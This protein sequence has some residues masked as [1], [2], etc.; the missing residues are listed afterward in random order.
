LYQDA[1]EAIVNNEALQKAVSVG[2]DLLASAD[3]EMQAAAV[4]MQGLFRGKAT[5][6]SMAAGEFKP[7]EPKSGGPKVGFSRN[8]MMAAFPKENPV[9]AFLKKALGVAG[10]LPEEQEKPN[11]AYDIIEIRKRQELRAQEAAYRAS[12]AVSKADA[13]FNAIDVNGDGVLTREEFVEK[14]NELEGTG[15]AASL[16]AEAVPAPAAEP[17][18]ALPAPLIAQEFRP[19]TF[20]RGAIGDGVEEAVT[21]T[22]D[23]ATEEPPAPPASMAKQ[24]S[25]QDFRPTTFTRGAIGEAVE[26]VATGTP[27]QTPE[28]TAAAVGA[29]AYANKMTGQGVNPFGDYKPAEPENLDVIETEGTASKTPGS[30]GKSLKAMAEEDPLAK[31]MTTTAPSPLKSASRPS[32]PEPVSRPSSPEP[33]PAEVAGRQSEFRS[34]KFTRGVIGEALEDEMAA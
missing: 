6:K 14:F 19:T 32:S 20:T 12:I 13:A 9:A 17:E 33:A 25:S 10:C 24:P 1:K 26:T 11:P 8:T 34:T 15:F 21:V 7:P 27:E 31:V 4:K 30:G 2:S 23:P 16:T 28:K 5:R 3:K 18:P 22:A 29:G